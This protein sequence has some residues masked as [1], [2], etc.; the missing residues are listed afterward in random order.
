[1]Y[2]MAGNPGGIQLGIL[3]MWIIPLML[4]APVPCSSHIVFELPT[5]T[6]DIWTQYNNEVNLLL[7]PLHLE[8]AS[9]DVSPAQAGEL[10][11]SIFKDFLSSKP[12]F[13][14]QEKSQTG[15]I[16]HDSSA[17]K[18]ASAE[19][20]AL[21]KRAFGKNATQEDRKA[22]NKAVKCHNYLKKL[23]E[24][25]HKQ[26]TSRHHEQQYRKNFWKFA[27]HC[28]D[29]NLDKKPVAP[30]FSELDANTYFPSKYG[31]PNPV[32]LQI[33][34]WFPYVP[35]RDDQSPAI[36]FNLE[37]IRPRDIRSVL[38]NKRATSA[39]G[40]DGIMYGILRK[41]PAT[42]HILA[43]IFSKL[44]MTGNPPD[45]WSNSSVTLI[46]KAGDAADPQNFRMIALTS[47][48]GKVFHQILSDRTSSYLLNN[49]LLDPSTQ[50]AFL[51]GINGCIEHSFVMNE[52]IAHARNKKKTIHVTFFDLAD[53]F[54]SVEHNL[55]N[56]TLKRNGIP[57]P[58]RN[59]VDNLYSRLNGTV[60]GPGWVS[61][62]FPFRRGVFQGDPLSPIIFL[63]VFNPIIEYL[64]MK[65]DT[66]GYDLNGS[67]YITLPFADDFCLITS[68]KRR[69]QKI[70]TEI[71]DITKTMNLTLKPVKCKSISICSGKSTDCTFSLGNVTLKS[72]K[73]NPEKFLGSN[74]TFEGKSKNIHELV[75]V[76]LRSMTENITTCSIRD[77]FKLKVYTQYAMP[78]VRYMLTVHELTDT[79]LDSLDHMHTNTVKSLMGLP[80]K[81]PT[82]A[83]IHSPDGLGFP[84]ISDIYSE[85]HTL[86]YARCMVKA[87]NRVVHALKS[88]IDRESKWKRKKARYGSNRWHSKFSEVNES[89]SDTIKWSDFK[90]KV[91]DL[92]AIDRTVFWRDY[93]KPLVQQG[94][95]LKLIEAEGADL[96]WRSIIFDLPRGVLSFAVRA[97]IDYLPT[98]CNLKTWGKRNST[99]CKFC[100]NQETLMHVLNSCSVSLNQGRFTWRHDS[101]LDHLLKQLK[102]IL[103]TSPDVQ[104]FSDMPGSTTTGGTLPVNIVISKLRPDIVMVNEKLKSVHLI[105]L[106]VPF[107]QNINKAHERK[108][109]KYNNLVSDITD[110]GYT[111]N[112]T[113]IEIGSRGL[114]TPDTKER[115]STIFSFGKAKAPKCL[116]KDLSKLSLLTSYTIWNARHDPS[117]GTA[118]QPHLKL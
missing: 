91:K 35:T 24:S 3:C 38:S 73:D 103:S 16:S 11:T 23:E 8:V 112:L 45:S 70:M 87:D 66:Y 13:V 93:I 61:T 97:S 77:E 30:T 75:Q 56:H 49:D 32:D 55:I 48:V 15:F 89:E 27:K 47:C 115:L 14:K 95:L 98:F 99:N 1:M 58:I 51:K 74:I 84:R 12:E 82:P 34:S 67:R 62:P 100:G 104:I 105:E 101:I 28:V 107:E 19:K 40:P 6:Q 2:S 108:T 118:D 109:L 69:H 5:L 85:S 39:P 94:N 50:K 17:L 81:G 83:F 54:G 78:S 65:E 26:N 92:I 44:I 42:H 86:A 96:T 22:F 102:Q 31:K 36:P 7:G 114:V 63:I 80:P 20:N 46:H 37:P 4:T 9:E 52:L 116:P 41:L 90:Q 33:V 106:T 88:K 57:E 72:L 10:F 59:Y 43:T 25:K 21:R 111:C 60:K 110:N 71:N 113:C 53:A 68:D 18:Q 64:K 29:G 76:K 79:Q 117:W